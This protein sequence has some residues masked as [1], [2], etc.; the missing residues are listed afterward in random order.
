MAAVKETII[1]YGGSGALGR[2]IVEK[3]KA[4]NYYVIS[5]DLFDNSAADANVTI[6]KLDKWVEQSEEVLQKLCHLLQRERSVSLISCVAGGWAGGNCASPEMISSCDLMWKQSVWSSTISAQI[7]KF[8]ILFIEVVL[9]ARRI[10][11]SAEF[12]YFLRLPWNVK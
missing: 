6:S 2:E 10:K 5:I 8:L 1:V 3:F 4:A 12:S 11:F 9:Y 7:G